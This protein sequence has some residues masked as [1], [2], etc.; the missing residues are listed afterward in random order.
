MTTILDDYK[1]NMQVGAQTSQMK[2]E[3]IGKF[4]WESYN[5]DTNSFDDDS[6]TKVGLFDQ[7]S[8]TRDRTDYLWYTT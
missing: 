6:F 2:M 5:E 8:M 4:S 7:I 1:I 3:W